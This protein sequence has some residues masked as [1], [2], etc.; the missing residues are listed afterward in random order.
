MSQRLEASQRD[1]ETSML[2][3]VAGIVSSMAGLFTGASPRHIVRAALPK[4]S[5]AL[6]IFINGL[7]VLTIL[8]VK[9][10]CCSLSCS[11]RFL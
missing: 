3:M 11:N 7:N 2:T 8:R 5:S 9:F 6:E 1:T 10:I 4:F